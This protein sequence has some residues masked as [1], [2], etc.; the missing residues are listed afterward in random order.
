MYSISA[1]RNLHNN[2]CESDSGAAAAAAS[3][4]Y[5]PRAET[6]SSTSIKVHLMHIHAGI[7]HSPTP[8][9]L[10]LARTHRIHYAV[11]AWRA[12]WSFNQIVREE[13][14]RTRPPPCSAHSSVFAHAC[15]SLKARHSSACSAEGRGPER[16]LES[17]ARR[18]LLFPMNTLYWSCCALMRCF[19]STAII[20]LEWSH[21]FT[22]KVQAGAF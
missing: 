2:Q 13:I 8:L 22:S 17:F 20:N 12:R 21:V 15:F 1:A 18:I 6:F 16:V 4:N 9:S 19:C 3:S 7:T 14:K 5:A 11:S 10:S